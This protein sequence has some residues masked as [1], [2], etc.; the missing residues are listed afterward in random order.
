MRTDCVQ[1][2]ENE[3]G[4]IKGYRYNSKNKNFLFPAEDVIDISL[5]SPLKTF[6]HT[7]K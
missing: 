3:D 1:L 2:E 4:S 5:Y 6:P 7:V